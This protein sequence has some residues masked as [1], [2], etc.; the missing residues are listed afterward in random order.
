MRLREAR[1]TRIS[2]S[3]VSD[4]IR[5]HLINKRVKTCLLSCWDGRHLSQG[6]RIVLTQHLTLTR[7]RHWGQN[8]EVPSTR[9]ASAETLAQHLHLSGLQQPLPAHS[10]C[11]Q[12]HQILEQNPCQNLPLLLQGSF[13]FRTALDDSQACTL[14]AI[15][16]QFNTD[17][18]GSFDSILRY[19]K[20]HL[21]L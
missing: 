11:Y 20:I 1:L 5:Q 21:L 18:F 15:I 12:H 16:C 9:L 17:V 4:E 8:G 2:R 3:W 7:A 14:I 6:L 10:Q 13:C 19:I